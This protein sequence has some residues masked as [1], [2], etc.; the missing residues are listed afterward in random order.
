[1]GR[2]REMPH[3]TAGVRLPS[4][5]MRREVTCMA[6]DM[7][8]GDA[9]LIG[10]KGG[11]WFYA[12]A[13]APSESAETTPVS[14]EDLIGGFVGPSGA[15]IEEAA[16]M[17][18]LA[19]IKVRGVKNTMLRKATV[20]APTTNWAWPTLVGKDDSLISVPNRI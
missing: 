17:N 13:P 19:V 1:M 15:S 8:Q 20:D 7:R 16:L 6:A 14:A 4:D 10:T 2:Y 5:F 12:D 9:A 18:P 3:D 11:A